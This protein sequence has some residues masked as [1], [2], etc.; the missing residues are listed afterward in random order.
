MAWQ[1]AKIIKITNIQNDVQG[2]SQEQTQAAA[3]ATKC[4]H[5]EKCHS[6]YMC[7]SIH[8]ITFS[9]LSNCFLFTALKNLN[10]SISLRNK[11]MIIKKNA[12]IKKML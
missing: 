12:I 9:F 3:T 1:G 2:V 4:F 10:W 11:M 7:R 8:Q 6:L 5:N